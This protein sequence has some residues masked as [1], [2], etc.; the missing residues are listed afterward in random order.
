MMNS[1]HM[2]WQAT[3]YV[4]PMSCYEILGDIQNQDI[5]EHNTV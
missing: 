1:Y 2:D 5:K 4:P 3:T